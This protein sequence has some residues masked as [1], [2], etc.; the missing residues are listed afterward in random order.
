MK[1]FLS[2]AAAVSLLALPA[3]GHGC[4]RTDNDRREASRVIRNIAGRVDALETRIV[5][6]LRLQTGQLSG[7][8]AQSA[9]A[10]T[11]ALDAQTALLA[12]VARE[13]EETRSMRAR[14]PSRSGCATVTGLS[15]MGASRV[16]AERAA[17]QA[18]EIETGRIVADRAVVQAAGAAADNAARFAA[19]T[20]AYC[21]AERLGEKAAACRSA[22]ER[23]G[24]DL[25]PGNL[26]DHS[27]IAA[28]DDLRTAIELSRNLASP[29]VHD[30]PSIAA[31]GTDQERRQVLLS[32]S[33]DARQ[34]LAA[35]FFGHARSLRAPGAELGGWA[36]AAIP[37]RDPAKSVSRYE[38]LEILASKRFESPE[39]FVRLQ[40]LSEANLLRELVM[41]QAVKLML[42]WERFRLD[43]R[44]GAVGAASLATDIER[45]RLL[46]GLANP[47][48]SVN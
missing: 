23:H 26:F 47:A 21:N 38:L 10:V 40:G 42:D 3:F 1:L 28:D 16:A 34:A 44:R 24:S 9:K 36:A 37:G 6:A 15:G 35:D 4:D 43:E 45:L 12:Q 22:P 25:K 2:A 48:G 39:W 14:R 46:P 5:E 7:Y 32:R 20:A 33:A 27:T 30:P 41:L 18:S 19:V 8:Q 29:V 13:V 31:A 11:G 17:A